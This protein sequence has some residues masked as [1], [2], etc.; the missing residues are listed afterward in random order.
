MATGGVLAGMGGVGKTQLVADY[1]RSAW[2]EG[3]LD[4]L[5]WITASSGSAAT[6]G[7]GQ[8]GVEVLGADPADPVSAAR[9]FLGW[10]EPKSGAEPCRWLVV[11]DDI[12]DPAALN[13]LW[14]PASPH[15]RTLA[16]TRRQDAALT[17]PGRQRI[18]V[19]VFTPVEAAD[20]LTEA[21]AARDR[22]EPAG[23]IAALTHDLGCLPLA[24]SQAAA[25]IIDTGKSCTTYRTLLADRARTLADLS[26]DVLPDGQN[27]TMAAAWSLSVEHADHLRPA[28]LARP[29]LQLAAFLDPNSIPLSVLTS[30]AA[31]EHLTA[32]RTANGSAPDTEPPAVDTDDAIGALRALQRLS[33]LHISTPSADLDSPAE[34]D[35]VVQAHQ[36]VQRATRDSLT[37][38][39][40]DQTARTA[41]DALAAAWPGTERDTVL[42]AA[43]R[44]NATT[45]F[46]TAQDA[47]LH[48][49]AHSVLFRAGRSLGKSGQVSAASDYFTR[50]HDLVH[51]YLGPDH[52]DTLT[53][54]NNQANWR[55][56]AGDA[57]GAATAYGELL[58]D[59]L[60]VLGPD[61][62]NTL[63]TRNNQANWRGRAGDTAGAA[64]AA[65]ELLTDQLRVLG[66]D[67]PDTLITRN[68]LAH[69]R[70]ESGDTAGAATAVEELLTN[71]LRVLGPDHLDTL[72][73][74][75]NLA[76]WRGESG[77]A[78][79]AATA[80]GELLTDQLRVLGPDHPDTLTT[81]SNL[82]SWRGEAGD[83]AG[84]ATA[85]EELLTD[86]LRVLGPDHPNTLTTRNN[87]AAWRGRA[88][89][90]AGAATAYGELLTDRLRVLGP[91]HPNTLTTRNNLAHWRGESGD[92]AGAATAAE[93]LLTDRLRV[94]GP[95]HPDT[96]T[97]RNN[98]ASWRGEA[99]D[100]AGAI[101][102]YEEL[103]SDQLRVLGPDHP[104]TLTTRSNLAAWRGQAGDAAG[105]ATAVEELLADR[106]RVLGP[107]HP[108]TLTTRNN[109]AAWRGRSDEGD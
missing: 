47:L 64:T 53:T 8:A 101:T 68:N 23:D 98:L 80:Y 3:K 93:E 45:L 96:L 27:H 24:L 22:I 52:L 65:E 63:T 78:A 34:S 86:Q 62:P 99:G 109:L 88:G 91:D 15:G 79:G 28:G 41:A 92:T 100:I 103:L 76:H 20:Y 17:G 39:Q 67:H 89:D 77:D 106:L 42:A 46:S 83:T 72:T 1:A 59:Q 35:E 58:T 6:A 33:L 82:A 102:A 81:R 4:V 29:M 56:E 19:G 44:A 12:A 25:Y 2:S 61:H 87:L 7:Y 90:A 69:W 73:T 32:H 30:E 54:R 18:E 75:N 38:D 57:A 50:L 95:D 31:L 13:G 85:A 36:I 5:V 49:D 74:R 43:L 16:T 26:P 21:L 10:L 97:T 51:Q 48:P 11:L 107:D 70:G 55:G 14:P 40:Y 94:L 37:P 108:N 9:R 60:R 66:P 71:F 105:A 84:A 104:D